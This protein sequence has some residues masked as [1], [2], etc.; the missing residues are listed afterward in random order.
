[1]S[2]LARRAARVLA[3][4]GGLIAVAALAIGAALLITPMQNVTVAGQVISVGT[5]TPGLSV[6]GPGQIDLFGQPLPTALQFTG[7]VRPRV[8]LTRITIDSEL[9][10]FVQGASTG[11]A[12]QLLGSALTDGWLRYFGWEAAIAGAAALLLAGAVAGWRRLQGWPTARLLAAA[13]VLTEL[14]NAGAVALAAHDTQQALRRVRSLNQ[15]VGSTPAR[16]AERKDPPAIPGV[17]AIVL[18]DSTAAGAGLTPFADSSRLDRACGRSQDSYAEDLA[19]AN[20]WKVMNLA[21]DSATISSGLLGGQGRGGQ[22]IAP[23]LDSAARASGAAAVI[24]SVGADDLQWSLLLEYCAAARHCDDRA[25]AAYFR[26]R[27]AVFSADYLQLL[28]RLAALPGRPAVIINRYYNPFGA[29]LRCV[30]R[31]GLSAP[32]VATLSSRLA[33][34]NRVLARGAAEFGDASP[35]PDFA[36]HQLC[37]A[38]PYVQGIAAPAPFHPTALGQLEIAIADEKV[39]AAHPA[40]TGPAS[41]SPA[42][43]SPP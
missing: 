12:T 41:P 2:Y 25:S 6:S 16:Q 31:R 17:H 37:S 29:D 3:G 9:A 28:T 22:M 5:V 30:T 24:V 15:L 21:C 35:K 34:L 13:L 42:A 20:G 39:L 40:G 36:G 32:N 11:R 26:Q 43:S 23:Q 14:A 1:M 38:Q 18:G 7:P 4:L 8:E 33:A 10:N 27:M 19:A